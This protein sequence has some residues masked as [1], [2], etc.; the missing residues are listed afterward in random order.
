[1]LFD[2]VVAGHHQANVRLLADIA[3]QTKNA[4]VCILIDKARDGRQRGRILLALFFTEIA[5]RVVAR[6][7]DAESI[8]TSLA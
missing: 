2:E 5:G 3:L 8:F 1:M 6:H 7:Q 4:D